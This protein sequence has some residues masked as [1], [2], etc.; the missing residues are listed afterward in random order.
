MSGCRRIAPIEG[1]PRAR[2]CLCAAVLIVAA[3]LAGCENGGDGFDYDRAREDPYTYFAPSRTAGGAAAQADTAQATA[4]GAQAST[5]GPAALHRDALGSEADASRRATAADVSSAMADAEA[6]RDR[7]RREAAEGRAHDRDVKALEA[8]QRR[9]E[10][11]AGA[12]I[13]SADGRHGR[14]RTRRAAAQDENA[15]RRAVEIDAQRRAA[16]DRAAT[17]P[18]LPGAFDVNERMQGGAF[19]FPGSAASPRGSRAPGGALPDIGPVDLP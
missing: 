8:A 14:E 1:S 5:A 10:K 19:G 4:Q 2:A 7:Q 13:V 17:R 15:L 12:G 3:A 9:R 16:A 11:A 18:D 6:R